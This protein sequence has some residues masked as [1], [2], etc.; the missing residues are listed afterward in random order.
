MKKR[1]EPD[2]T[3][4]PPV[5]YSAQL[6]AEALGF[7]EFTDCPPC[8]GQPLELDW[9]GGSLVKREVEV[10]GH[11]LRNTVIFTFKDFP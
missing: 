3:L 9:K 2:G 6:W 7:G 10:L 8:P 1:R 11:N 5:S 4:S